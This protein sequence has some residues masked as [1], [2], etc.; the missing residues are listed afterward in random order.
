MSKVVEAP[1]P[2]GATIRNK[3]QPQV[4]LPRETNMNAAII[5]NEIPQMLVVFKLVT[6]IL[7]ILWMVMIVRKNVK[8]KEA[9]KS[10]KDEK[11][12]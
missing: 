4:I 11:C 8:V 1:I 7:C 6:N 3:I 5:S 2:T 10:R 12:C 9:V